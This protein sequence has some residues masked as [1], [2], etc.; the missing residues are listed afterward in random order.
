MTTMSAADTSHQGPGLS[1]EELMSRLAAGGQDALGPLRGR[2]APLV[3]NL[4]AQSID[5]STA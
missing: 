2:C 3:Y 5:R 1:A 4:A